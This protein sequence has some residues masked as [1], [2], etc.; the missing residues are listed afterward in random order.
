MAHEERRRQLA[1][2]LR[3]CREN[4]QPQDVGIPAGQSRRRT[5]GLRRE[6]VADLAG[7]SVT[8]YAWIEQARD[9]TVSSN[10]LQRLADALQLRPTEREY[11][12]TLATPER[13]A[14]AD[15]AEELVT[16][17]LQAVLSCYGVN[18][19][20]LYGRRLD[21]LAS[22][23]AARAVFIDHTKLPVRE[24]NVVWQMFMNPVT[25]QFILDWEANAKGLLSI[26]RANWGRHPGDPAFAELITELEQGSPEF[27]AWWASHDVVGRPVERKELDHPLIGRLAFRQNGFQVVDCPDLTMVLYTPWPGTDTAEKLQ[28]LAASSGYPAGSARI[29]S[30]TRSPEPEDVADRQPG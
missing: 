6:E 25:R 7:I 11:L 22:N 16:P 28:R 8:W 1:D 26:L 15:D 2:F 3:A 9:I 13:R 29:P 19:A 17:A 5:K 23:E 18:P 12:F 24:R 21:I 10:V 20:Y 30:A 14:T 4:L 27:R